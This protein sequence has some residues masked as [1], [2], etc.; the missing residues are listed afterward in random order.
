MELN[1]TIHRDDDE[2]EDMFQHSEKLGDSY[3]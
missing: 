3:L 2:N 1:W